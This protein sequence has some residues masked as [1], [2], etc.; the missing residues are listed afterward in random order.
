MPTKTTKI[1]RIKKEYI[2]LNAIA[3]SR[4]SGALLQRSVVLDKWNQNTAKLVL[5]ITKSTLLEESQLL[6]LKK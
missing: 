2:A 6:K 3:L 1:S 5:I 4:E